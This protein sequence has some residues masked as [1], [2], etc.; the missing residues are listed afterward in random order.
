MIKVQITN[1]REPNTVGKLVTNAFNSVEDTSKAILNTLE[2]EDNS[3]VRIVRAL[4]SMDVEFVVSTPK[5]SVVEVIGYNFYTRVLNV[6]LTSGTYVYSNVPAVMFLQ[7]VNSDS[8]G[9]FFNRFI[10]GKF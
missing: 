8:K 5:S 7:F 4:Q 9:Q 3:D 1:D 2:E 10:K 6:H